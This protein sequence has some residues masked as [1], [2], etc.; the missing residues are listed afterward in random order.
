MD[1]DLFRELKLTL[2]CLERHG[3]CVEPVRSQ[4]RLEQEERVLRDLLS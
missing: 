4:V 1:V 3:V 2:F